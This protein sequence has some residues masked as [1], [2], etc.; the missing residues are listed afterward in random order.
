MLFLLKST[1]FLSSSCSNDQ[2]YIM[3]NVFFYGI[4][5]TIK[6]FQFLVLR[7][8]VIKT[9]KQKKGGKK[10]FLQLCDQALW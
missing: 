7:Y 3:L 6:Y 8:K 5:L 4:M 10:H 9:E 2:K 1:D